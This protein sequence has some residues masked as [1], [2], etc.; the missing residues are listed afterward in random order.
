MGYYLIFKYDTGIIDEMGPI[1][2][3]NPKY[4][5]ECPRIDNKVK[6]YAYQLTK[7]NTD[8]T[9]EMEYREPLTKRK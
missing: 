7:A 4:G 1:V 8:L 9:C 6:N 5:L 2:N 3:D